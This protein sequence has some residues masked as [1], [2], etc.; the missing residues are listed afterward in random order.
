MRSA[1]SCPSAQTKH[2]PPRRGEVYMPDLLEG[3]FNQGILLHDDWA[4][5]PQNLQEVLTRCGDLPT[6]I[7]QLEAARLLTP[8]QAD[9]LRAGKS[10][11][12]VMGNYR[13]VSRLGA[14]GMGVVFKAEHVL[15]RRP[16]AVKVLTMPADSDPKPLQRFFAEIRTLGSVQ[17]P[18]VVAPLDAGQLAPL[19]AGEPVLHYLVMEYVD[20]PDVEEM[21]RERGP[22]PV[23]LACDLVRQV[24]AGLAAAHGRQLVHRDVKPSNV[25]IRQLT[26]GPGGRPQYQAKL[27][28]F[29][30][31]QDF[32][33]RLTE[34]GVLLGTLDYVAPEQAQNAH[35]ADIRADIYGLGGVL[36]WCLTGQVPF[37]AQGPV[38][39][40]IIRRMTAPPPSARV[41]RPDVPPELDAVLARMLAPRP[42]DR[43]GT[44]EAVM[45][46][47]VPFLDAPPS[48]ILQIPNPKSQYD[49]RDSE[50]GA[51][52]LEFPAPRVL[53]VDD[54]ASV[55]TFCRLSLRGLKADLDEVE[56]GEDALALLHA[57]PYDVVVLDV[58]LPGLSGADVLRRLRSEPAM[59]N[60]RV[61]LLSGMAPPD[62]LARLLVAGADDYLA[63]PFTAAQLQGRVQAALR[64]KQA[65]DRSEQLTRHLQAVSTDLERNL[66]ARDCDLTQ[67]RSA[68][69]L[70]LAQVLGHRST[71]TEGHLVRVQHYSRLLAEAAAGV[72]PFNAQIDAAFI[73]DLECCAPLHDIGIVALPDHILM[74]PGKLDGEERVVMQSHTTI[75]AEIVQKVLKKYGQA[76]SFLRTAVDLARSHHERHDG[77]GYPDRLAGDAIPL[78]A[79]ILAVGD[80]YDALRSR[81]AHRPGLP[82]PSAVQVLAESSP[83]QFD[84][85]MIEVFLSI[86]PQFDVFFRQYPD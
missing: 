19:A 65:L 76:V 41:L 72:R 3:L 49:P 56:T 70:A 17:H 13:V 77:G 52:D 80:V 64:L 26:D 22:L 71:E 8:Y 7:D 66:T 30:L 84:P 34:P 15:L 79:R 81:R 59:A 21:V 24:A 38:P 31:A 33:N 27:L 62:D 46:A 11:G 50:F 43:Y 32:R 45:R 78:A 75:G 86:A 42:D 29:G 60:V 54:E 35:A 20:G 47:L 57:R 55:R 63:K 39:Q 37:P 51:S 44:P 36:F 28:D 1:L 4:Q 12:L 16:A 53:L 2:D 40:E 25:R 9:R 82:H 6:L 83:G 10:H 14:G 69:V 18:N 68:L 85:A 58:Q 73:R 74:K 5:I 23:P 67:A 61:L 48:G